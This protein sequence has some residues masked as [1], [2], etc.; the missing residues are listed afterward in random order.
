[1]LGPAEAIKGIVGEG[2]QYVTDLCN[3]CGTL[4]FCVDT[5]PLVLF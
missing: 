4:G 1:M 2:G 3:D 5:V